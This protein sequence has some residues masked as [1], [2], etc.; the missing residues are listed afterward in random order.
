MMFA[1]GECV[2]S[3]SAFVRLWLHETS[4]IY[5][6]K[7]IETKDQETFSKYIYEQIKKSFGVSILNFYYNIVHEP[8]QL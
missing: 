1:N 8:F 3:T 6:D 4:R 5:S 2:T 7:L